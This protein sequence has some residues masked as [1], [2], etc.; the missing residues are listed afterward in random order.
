MTTTLIHLAGEPVFGGIPSKAR[1]DRIWKSRVDSTAALVSRLAAMPA[2][3]RPGHLVCAS[4]V[5]FYGDRGDAPLSE[6]RP[7][8]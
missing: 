4:A 1:L 6:S 7:A 3:E 5:G 2:G 8:R